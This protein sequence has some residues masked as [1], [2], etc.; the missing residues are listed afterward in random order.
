MSDPG[1]IPTRIGVGVD[2]GP[3]GWDVRAWAVEEA[4][5]HQAELHVIHCGSSTA[6]I[7]TAR[8]QGIA[9]GSGPSDNDR[10]K[11]QAD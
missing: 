8:Q 1:R 7:D 11:R 4:S 2:G 10:I 9:T 6:V 5:L 3:G